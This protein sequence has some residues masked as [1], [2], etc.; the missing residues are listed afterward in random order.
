VGSLRKG[1]KGASRLVLAGALIGWTGIASAQEAP[2]PATVEGPRV[3]TPEDFTRF[4]PNNALDM[5]R[6]VPGFVIRE[7]IVE[8]GLGQATGNVLLNGQRLAGKSDDIQTQL[9][10]VPAQNVIRIEILDG[11]TLDIPGL[12][13]QVANVVVR[14]NAISG[15]FAWR[16]E[17]RARFTDPLFTRFDASVSGTMGPVEYTLGLENQSSHSGAGG[18]TRITNGDGTFR[19]V[20]DDV[21]TGEYNQ[22]RISGRFVIDGPGSSVGNL[23]VSYREFWYDFIENGVRVGPG[24]PDRERQV[25]V[26]EDG[27]NY[28]INGDFEFAFGPGRLKLIGLN[29]F[30]HYVPETQ[31]VTEFGD[32][33]PDEGS[34]FER[35]GEETERIARAEYRWN[36]GGADWQVSA[37]AAFNALDNVSS[38]FELNTAGEFVEEPLPGGTARVEEDRYEV[39]GSYSRP[40][41]P[42]LSIQLSAGGEYSQLSQVGEGGLTRTFWRPK[43]LFS[44]AWKPDPRTDVNF[45]LQ[46]RVGQINFFDFLASVDLTD[47]QES[48][49]NPNLV[50]PQSWEAEVEWVRNLG[51][52]GTSTIRVYGHLIEDIIDIIPIGAT[53]EAVGNIDRAIRYG[54]EGKSTFNF[55]PMG[56][57]GAKLDARVQL[58][59]SRLDDPLTGEP[60]RISNSLMHLVSLTL[61][62]DVPATD[63]AWGTGMS[64]EFYA[65]D[66]RLTEVGRLWEGPVWAHVYV[67]HKD[68]LGLTVR[69]TVNNI[70]GADSMWDRTVYVGRRTGPI[71]YFER[72]D[73]VIGP[74][75]SFQI[76]GRF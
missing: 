76:R 39:M 62:H 69:A 11:A 72:R 33:Q 19:E 31:V 75:F 37:E 8:R 60:R 36:G 32:G 14:A 41:A 9:G 51:P 64:H 73:R 2:P 30:D 17:L 47:D 24:L 7:A 10:R 57:R 63:W 54:I 3:F 43:G 67:E 58:Q 27:H 50:P 29:R 22:P 55:D 40:L 12:S 74:I 45:R 52:W 25:L 26:E 6:Q 65:R 71:D 59:D 16:P 61:R 13:G 70:L 1:M 28:E 15:Q 46:R 49:G 18:I 66:V 42:N 53:G 56:W 34:R 5:I 4:A 21:W 20:R 68:V 44:A 48:A 35:D 38:L 23:N